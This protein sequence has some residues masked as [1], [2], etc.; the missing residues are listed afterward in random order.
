MLDLKD[1]LTIDLYAQWAQ[2]AEESTQTAD[3][4]RPWL[5]HPVFSAKVA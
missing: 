1:L 3:G 2:E 4:E 5:R